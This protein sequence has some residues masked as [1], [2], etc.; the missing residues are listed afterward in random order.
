MAGLGGLRVWLR[1]ALSHPS[2][3]VLCPFVLFDYLARLL[4][5]LLPPL[6]STSFLTLRLMQPRA[7]SR[8]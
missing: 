8:A 2:S 7:Q 3:S 4:H 5:S 6:P 1:A